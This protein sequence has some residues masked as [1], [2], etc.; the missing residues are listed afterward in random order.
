MTIAYRFA[1]ASILSPFIYPQV[2]FMAVTSW[3]VFNQP[4]GLTI[5][6]GTPDRHRLGRLYLVARAAGGGGAQGEGDR[7][8]RRAEE[9][10]REKETI[11]K[12]LL[13]LWRGELLLADAFWTWAVTV[14]LVLNLTTT[15]LFVAL[16]VNDHPWEALVVGHAIS[17]PY[18]LRCRGRG[19][20]VG[21]ALW[22][23]G[24]SRRARPWRQPVAD[25]GAVG[26]L[27]RGVGDTGIRRPLAPRGA[28]R[29]RG[30]NGRG[31]QTGCP[32]AGAAPYSRRSGACGRRTRALHS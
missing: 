1:E 2:I 16:M 4:P 20:A 26:H 8:G 29:R 13:A 25:G 19:L 11:V 15:A 22:R 18:N 17:V 24:L 27:N 30:R 3:L 23:T 10:R 21:F 9:W 32:A 31:A 6:V 12:T 14:G 7:G 28:R 5:Y